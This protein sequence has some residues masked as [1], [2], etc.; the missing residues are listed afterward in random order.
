MGEA[1]TGWFHSFAVSSADDV[2]AVLPDVKSIYPSGLG[3]AS[4]DMNQSVVSF[5]V[6][7][8]DNAADYGKKGGTEYKFYAEKAGDYTLGILAMA[9]NPLANR[10]KLTLN[11]TCTE[12]WRKGILLP[13]YNGRVVGRYLE[14]YKDFPAKRD[15]L[16][17]H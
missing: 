17:P 7:A 12:I 6:N 9:G 10:T 2:A 5:G 14:L 13:R 16:P 3:A 1:Y 15:K 8:F 11:D 4:G